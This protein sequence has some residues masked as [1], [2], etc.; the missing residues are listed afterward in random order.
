M[1]VGVARAGCPGVQSV[2]LLP[3]PCLCCVHFVALFSLGHLR[4]A[5]AFLNC[6][7]LKAV[8]LLK[9]RGVKQVNYF[10]CLTGSI[11]SNSL[12]TA[13]HVCSLAVDCH[14]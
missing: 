11:S 6:T 13:G 1:L 3:Q 8:H 10:I 7:N 5:V 4:L 12:Q 14:C 9:S 2:V